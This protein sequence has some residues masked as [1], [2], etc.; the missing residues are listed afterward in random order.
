MATTR[1][2]DPMSSKKKPGDP[3]WVDGHGEI[4][5]PDKRLDPKPRYCYR[6]MRG[7]SA[8]LAVEEMDGSVIGWV[9]VDDLG[10]TEPRGVKEWMEETKYEIQG[11]GA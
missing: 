5:V 1:H 7:Y 2:G 11:D 4:I 6:P 3:A 8:S 9:A 10:Y